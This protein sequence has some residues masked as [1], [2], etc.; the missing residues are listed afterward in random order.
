MGLF[1][2]VLL[3]A[4]IILVD[5]Q[6]ALWSPPAHS[7]LDSYA[8]DTYNVSTIVEPLSD[9]HPVPNCVTQDNATA[10]HLFAMPACK[11]VRIEDAT[12]DELQRYLSRGRLTSVDLVSC[13][14]QRSFQTGEY[15]KWAYY[16]TRTRLIQC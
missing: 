14:M 12:I 11:G 3:C 9:M 8:P 10:S 2:K 16:L 6:A 13:Y 5:V 4:T 1:A 7:E 15:I